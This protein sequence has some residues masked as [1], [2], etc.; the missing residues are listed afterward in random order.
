MTSPLSLYVHLPWCV[1]KCP[2]CDFNS[3]ALKEALP[4]EAYLDALERDLAFAIEAL[5]ETRPLQSIFFGGGTP[6]L[7]NPAAIGRIIDHAAARLSFAPDAEITLEANPGTIE[8]GRFLDYR[9]AGV[10]RVSLGVQSFDDGQLK[11]LG[12]IHDSAAAAQAI[13]ELHAAGLANFNIDLMFAL[14]GQATEAAMHDIERALQAQPAHISHYELTLEPNTLFAVRPPSGLPDE[15]AA[16]DIAAACR[17]RLAQADYER[18]EISAFARPGRRSRHNLNYWS[19]GDY[20]GVGAGAHGKLTHR[21]GRTVRTARCRHPR[22]YLAHAGTGKAIAEEREVSDS[23]RVFEYML[24]RSRL[25]EGGHPDAFKAATGLDAG[26]WLLPR[27]ARGIELGLLESRDDGGWRPSN[28]GL[29][30]LNEIQALFLPA[31]EMTQ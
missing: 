14:P 12:R 2:Y 7:F 4:E 17:E 6:S 27:L 22:D 1:R 8:R 3:H 23:E 28:R 24:N 5:D 19:Y 9:D 29:E 13:E 25:L 11:T 30:L 31:T 26:V 18:Y 16:M 10:N 20:I 21:D 15:D